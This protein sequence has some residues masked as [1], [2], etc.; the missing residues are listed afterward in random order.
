V[1]AIL[2]FDFDVLAEPFPKEMLNVVRR[3]ID[4]PAGCKSAL[5]M[6]HSPEVGFMSFEFADWRFRIG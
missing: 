4:Q 2:G 1:N 3:H 6:L 5:E